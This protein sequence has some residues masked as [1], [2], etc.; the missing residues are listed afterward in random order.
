[1]AI[2]K[3]YQILEEQEEVFS[4]TRT[5]CCRKFKRPAQKTRDDATT[6]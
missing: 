1:M 6:C 4:K 2:D 3:V 5:D